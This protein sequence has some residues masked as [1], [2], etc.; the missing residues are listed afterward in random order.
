MQAHQLSTDFKGSGVKGDIGSMSTPTWQY[1]SLR[2]IY[3]PGIYCLLGDY[4]IP[5]TY[6]RASIG[7][8]LLDLRHL[9]TLPDLQ[10]IGSQTCVVF[11]DH[12]GIGSS[13]E[14]IRI[15]FRYVKTI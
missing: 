7:L 3:I 11:G 2:Y 10:G 1:I 9:P 13:L 12:A 15:L 5:T 4:I 8:Q 6:Y 14:I